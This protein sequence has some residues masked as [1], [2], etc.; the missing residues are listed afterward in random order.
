MD[1][2]GNNLQKK[3]DLLEALKLVKLAWDNVTAETISNCFKKAG[4]IPGIE[5]NTAD[6]IDA[7]YEALGE[8]IDQLIDIDENMDCFEE[9]TDEDIIEEV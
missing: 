4:F 9:F 3:I 8:E 5:I 7:L 6:E 1:F 2:L